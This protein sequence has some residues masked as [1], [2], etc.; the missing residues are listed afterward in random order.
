M[1]IRV[2]A[3]TEYASSYRQ[4]RNLFS[5]ADRY[6]LFS[7]I[8]HLPDPLDQLC[9]MAAHPAPCGGNRSKLD[10]MHKSQTAETT[11]TNTVIIVIGRTASL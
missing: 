10:Q 8:Q 6:A 4:L 7:L 11:H 2:H 5:N 9:T 1:A 3:N